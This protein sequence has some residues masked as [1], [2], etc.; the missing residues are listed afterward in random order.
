MKVLDA[1]KIFL[2][3]LILGCGQ[4]S[5]VDSEE[6]CTQYL[7]YGTQLQD[8]NVFLIEA[9]K[10]AQWNTVS[11]ATVKWRFRD[12][13]FDFLPMRWIVSP[14]NP[15]F[16]PDRDNLFVKFTAVGQENIGVSRWLFKFRCLD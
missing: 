14:E 13:E 6:P 2:V 10:D 16:D 3:L 15:N 8:D 5:I 1:V 4:S 9:I 7:I 11:I 12:T